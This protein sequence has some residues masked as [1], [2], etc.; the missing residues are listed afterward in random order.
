MSAFK[1]KMHEIRFRLRLPRHS[2][3][4]G[5]ISKGGRM[6]EDGKGCEGR[7]ETEGDLNRVTP[8]R[9]RI[10]QS[11][12]HRPD[13]VWGDTLNLSPRA[14]RIRR[15]RHSVKS[16]DTSRSTPGFDHIFRIGDTE[17]CHRTPGR[18][19]ILCPSTESHLR[20][21]SASDASA[22]YRRRAVTRARALSFVMSAVGGDI[23]KSEQRRRIRQTQRH[24]PLE[25]AG[26]LR[27]AHAAST[28]AKYSGRFVKRKQLERWRAKRKLVSGSK[29]RELFCSVSRQEKVWYCICKIL[30]YS[31]FWPE[32]GSHC[33]L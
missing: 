26:G 3:I 27:A 20:L 14:T 7:R 12:S 25:P 13:F 9:P 6:G 15:G 10:W 32:N 23:P 1:G 21:L 31:A 19:P 30:Q 24:L 16:R 11:Y 5:P 28:D 8:L 2:W 17:C 22:I 33:R 29:H 18:C 4:Y